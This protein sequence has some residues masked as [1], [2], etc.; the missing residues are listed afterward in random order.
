MKPDIQENMETRIG[1]VSVQNTYFD[2]AI[3]AIETETA[4]S[5]TRISSTLYR[6]VDSEFIINIT[7]DE[8]LY[9]GVVTV[10]IV[11]NNLDGEIRYAT[12]T[13]TSNNIISESYSNVDTEANRTYMTNLFG[14][15]FDA[16]RGIDGG[17]S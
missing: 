14:A 17:E 11:K 1:T 10:A 3:T 12:M 13:I 5:A 4:E 16:I 15:V 8:S 2:T 7:L 9:D 6:V